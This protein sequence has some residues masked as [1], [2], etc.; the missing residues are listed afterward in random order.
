MVRFIRATYLF[1]I[2]RYLIKKWKH[3]VEQKW[4]KDDET[5]SE[6]KSWIPG[7]NRL[8][9][10]TPSSILLEL[11]DLKKRKANSCQV[12]DL[13]KLP[14]PSKPIHIQLGENGF[15]FSISTE[16]TEQDNIF[17]KLNKSHCGQVLYI[18]PSCPC[19]RQQNKRVK[20]AT[21]GES[22]FHHGKSFKDRLY[23]I[24]DDWGNFIHG[25]NYSTYVWTGGLRIFLLS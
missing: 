6:R 19:I 4:R 1:K 15:T 16:H 23:P 25:G 10:W 17:K 9:W 20:H 14:H 5:G 2:M 11:K 8:E 21:P 18:P 3:Q 13:P 12:P 22:W 24:R 7:R